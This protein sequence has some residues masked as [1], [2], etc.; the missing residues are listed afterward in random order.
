MAKLVL[1]GATNVI[2]QQRLHKNIMLWILTVISKE[3]ILLEKIWTK[4][5]WREI[6]WSNKWKW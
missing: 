3:L 5:Q 2:M 4:S 1:E 6:N